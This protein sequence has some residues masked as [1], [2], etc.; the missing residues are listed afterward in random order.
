M[1]TSWSPKIQD[2][3]V[4]GFRARLL[5]TTGRLANVKV[6]GFRGIGSAAVLDFCGETIAACEIDQGA[7]SLEMGAHQW[8]ELEATWA[9]MEPENE[10]EQ[11][12]DHHD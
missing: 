12:D 11:R 2:D 8:V 10:A 6:H 9:G 4:I 3:R 5:E 1:A 7:A